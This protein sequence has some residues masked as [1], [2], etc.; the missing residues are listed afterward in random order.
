MER[1]VRLVFRVGRNTFKQADLRAKLAIPPLNQIDGLDVYGDEQRVRV[2]N[3]RGPWQ[4]VVILAHTLGEIDTPAFRDFLAKA[5]AAFQGNL[6]RLRTT[7]EDVMPWKVNGERWHLGEKGFPPGRTVRWDRALLPR[8]LKLVQEVEPGVQVEW[9]TRD[10][11]K[12][13]VPG[14]N[15]AWA[16]WRTKD[17]DGLD[18]RFLGKKGQF[19]LSR[20]ESFGVSP[21]I[22]ADRSAGDVLKLQFQ[23]QEQL[24]AERLKELL[25]EHLGGFRE[26]FGEG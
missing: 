13:R 11:I 8:L 15:R 18:C 4:E 5:V 17:N 24:H 7:P 14:I 23:H 22:L 19:N 12:L 2:A 26:V 3:R 10:A 6:K 9:D 20:I 25:A 21:E 1:T 16:Q